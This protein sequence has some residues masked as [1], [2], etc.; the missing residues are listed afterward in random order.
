[1]ER[2]KYLDSTNHIVC[3]FR[4]PDRINYEKHDLVYVD[5]PTAWIQSE[6]PAVGKVADSF[7]YLPNVSLLELKVC[8]LPL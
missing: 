5:G 6:R 3:S 8:P 1:M 2:T 4:L 7:G